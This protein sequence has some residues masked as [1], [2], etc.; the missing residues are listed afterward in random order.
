VIHQSK[1]LGLSLLLLLLMVGGCSRKEDTAE[2]KR[3]G[4]FQEMMSGVTLVG[5]STRF[6]Q[7]GMFG[8]ERYMIDKVSKLTGDTWLFRTRLKYGS[9]EI[10]VPIPL[11]VRWAGDTPVISLTDLM[12]PG[13][14]TYTARILLHRD[15]Y[16][17]TWSGETIGGQVFGKIIRSP[18]Q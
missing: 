10:P 16:A 7:D 11:T 2:A 8:E 6:D 4:E 12:I 17:G 3:N 5:H 15:Q 1:S 18:Q 13:V 9:H 14:G